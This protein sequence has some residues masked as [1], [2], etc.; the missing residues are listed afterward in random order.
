MNLEKVK[1]SAE[2]FETAMYRNVLPSYI[3]N[4]DAVSSAIDRLKKPKDLQQHLSDLFEA[5]SAFN[6]AMFA[7]DELPEYYDKFIELEEA[8]E[9]LK[10]SSEEAPVEDVKKTVP[11]PEFPEGVGDFELTEEQLAEGWRY[12]NGEIMPVASNAKIDVITLS[13]TYTDRYTAGDYGDM[14]VWKDNQG[15]PN[16]IILAFRP[17]N[18]D[19][20]IKGS[21]LDLPIPEHI[22]DKP[23]L[24]L[25]AEQI[26]DGWMYH[27]G[28]ALPGHLDAPIVEARSIDGGYWKDLKLHSYGAKDH[29]RFLKESQHGGN[30]A[31]WAYK[32]DQ[33]IANKSD[34]GTY[35]INQKMMADGWVLHDG[36]GVPEEIGRDDLVLVKK[37]G[38]YVW[39]G[40]GDRRITWS[41]DRE[42]T[43]E[44]FS[45][46]GDNIVAYKITEKASVEN[47]S[48]KLSKGDL[49]D[50][51]I[52]HD[53]SGMP[54]EPQA[55]VYIMYRDEA[56]SEIL[57]T[58]SS[59]PGNWEWEED[60]DDEYDIVAYKVVLDERDYPVLTPEMKGEGW[61]VHDGKTIPDLPEKQRVFVILR[62]APEEAEV[63]SMGSLEQ[64][65][66]G[67]AS[68]W[69]WPNENREGEYDIIA[70]RKV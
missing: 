4:W 26:K 31:I 51:W 48:A 68:Q 52:M 6:D 9:E 34:Q 21:E 12:H 62:Y 36:K 23:H 67:E 59:M 69:L 60:S 1:K 70:W 39:R 11:K 19:V 45:D 65:Y 14:W 15:Y 2:E 18:P 33:E 24:R 10:A 8:V 28:R 32:I 47:Y 5:V 55:L 49:Q 35:Y 58:A 53:G 17:H 16:R 46:A 41:V 22:Q 13:K 50:G 44:P 64:T 66:G 63:E 57:D 29:N 20:K 37:R 42:W 40:R 43:W 56:R 27:D 38:G 3:G 25:T 7:A 30:L 54:V 61:V